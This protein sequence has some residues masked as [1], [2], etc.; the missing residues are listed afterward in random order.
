MEPCERSRDSTAC[1]Y[2][3][4]Y[5][6][7]GLSPSKK[8]QR[9]DLVIAMKVQGSGELSTCLQIKLYK[10]RD[11]QHCEWGSRLHCI[12]LDCCAHE[13]AMAVTVNK[14]TY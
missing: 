13:G 5:S 2:S 4:Y 12:E 7:D 8:G 10:A 9:Q 1:A 14:E 3:S 6:T 11:T